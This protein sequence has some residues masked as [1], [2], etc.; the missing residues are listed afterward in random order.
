MILLIP[1]HKWATLN[2]ISFRDKSIGNKNY[3]EKTMKPV[4]E[5]ERKRKRN[6]CSLK[7]AYSA[8]HRVS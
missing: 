6:R 5:V 2:N 3:K 4:T 8:M 7:A 1:F